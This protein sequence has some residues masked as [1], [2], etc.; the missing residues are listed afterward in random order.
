M[1]SSPGSV[2]SHRTQQRIQGGVEACDEP[3]HG[4]EELA[5]AAAYYDHSGDLTWSMSAHLDVD[6]CLLG[7][8]T[9]VDVTPMTDLVIACNE[10]VLCW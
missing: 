5:I 4:L 6:R 8:E 7:S 2:L 1:A 9:P 3:M 10:R